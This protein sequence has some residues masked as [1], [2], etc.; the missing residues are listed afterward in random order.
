MHFARLRPGHI[1]NLILLVV[2]VM[3]APATAYAQANSCA[4]LANFMGRL[5]GERD[6]RNLQ[7][8]TQQAERLRG[9]LQRIERAFVQGGCQ[10]VAESGQRLSGDCLA[11]ARQIQRGREDLQT[12]QNRVQQG[13]AI[14][15]RREEVRT[16]MQRQGCNARGRSNVTVRRNDD[17]GFFQQLFDALQGN[18]F[19]SGRVVDQGYDDYY[20]QG[21]GNTVRSVCVRTCDG[22]YWPVSFATFSDYLVNDAQQCQ[23]LCPGTEVELYYYSN[24]G[25]NPEDMRNLD[26]EPYT[27]LPNAFKYRE[28]YDKSCT[29]QRQINFGSVEVVRNEAGQ[30]RQVLTID[31]ISVPLPIADPR[32][33]AEPVVA[34]SETISI[35]LP[36]PR[37]KFNEDGDVADPGIESADAQSRVETIG[38]RRVRIVGPETPY[39]QSGEEGS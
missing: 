16:Q 23:S 9:Q 17:R 39:A 8:Y 20:D 22:Y 7:Q 31:D 14:A 12:L 25:E 24:P 30:S 28:E 38:G 13:R 3:G 34:A 32:N 6:F 2:I 18:D 29:C 11:A 35:P 5:E 1:V 26:G 27:A 4:Q 10:R 33:I 21:Y 36:R 19:G 15:Q 37:P